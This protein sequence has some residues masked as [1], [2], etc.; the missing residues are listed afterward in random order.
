MTYQKWMKWVDQ[1]V[2]RY[3][4]CSVHDLPDFPS[5]DL[6]EQGYTPDDAAKTA[7][8]EAADYS[9]YF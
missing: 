9:G 2:Y 3:I 1:W 8:D 5:R 4:G 7:V 6:Y